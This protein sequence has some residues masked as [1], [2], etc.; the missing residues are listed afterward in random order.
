MWKCY[1]LSEPNKK[2]YRKR[3]FE[4]WTNNGGTS[5]SEQRICDQRR[6]IEKK[7]WLTTIERERVK[8]E[9]EGMTEPEVRVPSIDPIEET[10]TPSIPDDNE[11]YDL[12]NGSTESIN[13]TDI[14]V[15]IVEPLKTD[16]P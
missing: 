8:R 5:V 13:D 6:M 1:L 15:I 12:L 4:I 16:I 11:N 9:I 10:P 3:F 14:E 2:G 7:G